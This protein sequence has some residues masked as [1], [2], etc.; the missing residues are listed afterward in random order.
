MR[1]GQSEHPHAVSRQP[2]PLGLVSCTS[3]VSMSAYRQAVRHLATYS[4]C[5]T[6]HIFITYPGFSTTLGISGGSDDT[7]VL[8]MLSKNGFATGLFP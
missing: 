6:A 1:L 8:R 5:K 7:L 3:P 2:S 4:Q